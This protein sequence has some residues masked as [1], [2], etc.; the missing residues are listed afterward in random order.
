MTG[1]RTTDPRVWVRELEEAG[2][3]RHGLTLFQAPCGC[4]FR[5]PYLAWTEMK[6]THV[7]DHIAYHKDAS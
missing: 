7:A 4:Y 1:A 2:W 6:G 3:T 5:G